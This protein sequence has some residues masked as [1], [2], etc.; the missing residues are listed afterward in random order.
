MNT[1]NLIVFYD[2]ETTGLP[3]WQVPSDDASQ[4]HLVQLGAVLCD[5]NTQEVIATLNVIIKPDG[6]VI[7]EETIA[8]HGITNEHAA[9]FGIPEKE[10][11]ELFLNLVGDSDR[12]AFNKTF[13]QRIVRIGLKRY[14]N[15]EAQEKWA[16][17]ENHH[18]SMKMA[19]DFMGVKSV[20]LVDAYEY[21]TG[22]ILEDAHDA[23]ADAE[24][25]MS[26]YFSINPGK[27]K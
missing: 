4:P 26:V 23:F 14:F 2:A 17:K 10:A 13:D 5:V 15:E 9:E 8:I 22:K 25:C 3:V 16:E 19:K 27:G 12:C 7:P 6:W 20:K 11:L 18:C 24:A 1:E 21:L